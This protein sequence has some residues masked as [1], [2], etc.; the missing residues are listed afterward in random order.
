MSC[1]H[2]P[3]FFAS[4]FFV[5][6]HKYMIRRVRPHWDILRHHPPQMFSKM[7]VGDLGVHLAS[8]DDLRRSFQNLPIDTYAPS[9]PPTR[10]RRHATGTV[11]I[12]PTPEYFEVHM[13]RDPTMFVQDVADDRSVPRAFHPMEM[14]VMNDAL[15]R[16]IVQL[17]VLVW[18]YRPSAGHIHYHIHQ[19]RLLSYPAIPSDNA[20]EGIHQDGADWIVSALVMN[21]SNVQ[22]DRSVV[23]DSNKRPVYSTCLDEGEFI[24]QDDRSLWHDI[25]P[26]E[27]IPG[28]VGYRDILGFDFLVD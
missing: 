16:M 6:L 2:L 18:R 20:P 19:V 23:Y 9:A 22:H 3:L 5:F 8:F 11:Y 25:T 13:N 24:F 21:K 28:Y 10:F 27:C 12:P 14:H 15:F 1:V 4:L 26:I 17:S 7:N